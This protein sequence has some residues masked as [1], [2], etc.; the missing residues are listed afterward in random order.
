MALKDRRE[1]KLSAKQCLVVDVTNVT[2]FSFL[3]D[4]CFDRWCD[5]NVFSC[6]EKDDSECETGI[7]WSFDS[8]YD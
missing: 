4:I 3:V 2:I 1:L 7:I 6:V 5:H 8:K